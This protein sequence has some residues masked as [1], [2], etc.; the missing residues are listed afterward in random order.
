M[1]LRVL[2]KSKGRKHTALKLFLLRQKYL[3]SL[4]R[5]IVGWVRLID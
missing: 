5:G 4:R 1:S 2:K 3:K